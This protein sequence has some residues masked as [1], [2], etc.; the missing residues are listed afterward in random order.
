MGLETENQPRRRCDSNPLP[1][2][3]EH[4]VAD[5]QSAGTPPADIDAFVEQVAEVFE[6][7][8]QDLNIQASLP[9]RSGLRNSEWMPC[10]ALVAAA[11]VAI[12]I[13]CFYPQAWLLFAGAAAGFFVG[14]I[15]SAGKDAK[16]A[17]G[18]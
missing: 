18:F 8:P 13:V 5:M 15:V 4:I 2:I 14:A 1:L 6:P 7:G 17:T 11:V 16:H 12:S 9:P 10:M 3:A